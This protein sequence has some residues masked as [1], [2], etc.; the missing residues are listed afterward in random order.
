[1]YNES[2]IGEYNHI[3]NDSESMEHSI[4]TFSWMHGNT[5]PAFG[6][7]SLRYSHAMPRYI[8]S[9][10][11]QINS[12]SLPPQM[13]VYPLYLLLFIVTIIFE[14][15]VSTQQRLTNIE[16]G[17][18]P[19]GSKVKKPS[20]FVNRLGETLGMSVVIYIIIIAWVWIQ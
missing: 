18:R 10:S 16:Q 12:C 19:T 11:Y 15:R 20:R 7:L 8:H 3:H 17:I 2:Y 9:P 4:A 1:M 13:Y 14:L 5:Y 6:M